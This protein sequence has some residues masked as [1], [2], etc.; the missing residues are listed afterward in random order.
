MS[1]R[2]HWACPKY[3]LAGYY[4]GVRNWWS[5]RHFGPRWYEGIQCRGR[6]WARFVGY[7]GPYLFK[8]FLWD[9]GL[10]CERMA[11]KYDPMVPR[12]DT[13]ADERYTLRQKKD[14]E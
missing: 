4:W 8:W 3:C 7:R 2:A 11:N 12:K 1:C 13:E 10:W 9:L 6:N 14:K 5:N